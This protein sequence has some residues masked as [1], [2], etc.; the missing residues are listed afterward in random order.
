[1]L[2]L[3]PRLFLQQV[4]HHL[5]PESDIRSAYLNDRLEATSVS[6]S[7]TRNERGEGFIWAKP[8][9]ML[10]ALTTC[11][12]S[13]T[14]TERQHTGMAAISPPCT[15]KRACA[16]ALKG[17]S[18]VI[19]RPLGASYSPCNSSIKLQKCC[20]FRGRQREMGKILCSVEDLTQSECIVCQERTGIY[21]LQSLFNE[22]SCP[23]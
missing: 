20:Q 19:W 17:N 9:V 14:H 5:R 18:E 10:K 13:H 23:L 4:W 1:M 2:L 7:S 11:F 15:D 12:G 6:T 16:S 8:S 3:P 22:K 21:Q